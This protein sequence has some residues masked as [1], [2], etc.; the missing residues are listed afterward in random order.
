MNNI[1]PFFQRWR[2]SLMLYSTIL[3]S[4]NHINNWTTRKVVSDHVALG[5]PKQIQF[6]FFFV[7][8]P[9]F[10]ATKH[11]D[12][13]RKTQTF[14]SVK[15]SFQN[16]TFQTHNTLCVYCCVG[17]V[18]LKY[19][20]NIELVGWMWFFLCYL[21]SC[22]KCLQMPLTVSKFDEHLSTHI[23]HVSFFCAPY[24]LS[25]TC[26]TMNDI[27]IPKLCVLWYLLNALMRGIWF[28]RV[29]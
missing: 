18:K 15:R 6:I 9:H 16:C 2:A 29:C 26:I 11:C 27:Q 20:V 17:H 22:Y 3:D 25:W 8:R 24:N 12:L 13:Y 28:D 4:Q 19:L 23:S 1:H 10:K 5:S 7:Y 21:N 14:T